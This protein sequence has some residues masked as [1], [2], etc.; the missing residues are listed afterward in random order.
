MP[1][2]KAGAFDLEYTEPAPVPPWS[3]CTVRRVAYANGGG[4]PRACKTATG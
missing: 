2:I 3:W 1:V 4:W